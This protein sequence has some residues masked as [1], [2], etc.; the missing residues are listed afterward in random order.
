[1][2]QIKSK[3]ELDL[4]RRSGEL[5]ATVL[6]ELARHVREGVSLLEL[7]QIA[8]ELTLK[9]GAVPAFKG[10]LGYK[11]VL[12]TSVNEQVVHGIP[13]DRKL[14]SGDIVGLDF[15]L[16]Q[17][18]FFGDSAVTLPVGPV[19]T[20]ARQLMEVTRK[21]LY[22]G[23]DAC[24]VGNSLKDIALAIEST[25]K[26]Y[27]YGIVRE[28]VGHGIGTRLHEN[29]QVPN[30]AAGASNLKLKAGMTLALEPMINEGTEGV[31]VLA[32]KWTAVTVDG[33]LSAHF[34]HT[35]AITDGDPE[36]LTEWKGFPFGEPLDLNKT[37]NG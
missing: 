6:M 30:Y 33:K 37:T 18:G 27:H 5:V 26:P 2:V 8:E 12:C 23:I 11:H 35:V 4:M 14:K 1:M 25:V 9:M 16:S 20:R 22:A 17:E 29:P 19:S 21:S 24:R 36:I 34:E 10:Y 15:G 28:F 31:R 3:R 13:S 7:N 32:D